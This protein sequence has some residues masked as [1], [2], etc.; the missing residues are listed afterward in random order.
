M[1]KELKI[2]THK[3]RR[4]KRKQELG[5]ISNKFLKVQHKTD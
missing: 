2:S 4:K 3:I 5:S 1:R